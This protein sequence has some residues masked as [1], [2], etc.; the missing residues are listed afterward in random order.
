[1]VSPAGAWLAGGCG[2]E[3]RQGAVETVRSSG[4]SLQ[5]EFVEYA[6]WTNFI[7][8]VWIRLIV[9]SAI[10]VGTTN[11][12]NILIMRDKIKSHCNASTWQP[13]DL[14]ITKDWHGDVSWSDFL[15]HRVLYFSF[16]LPEQF[17]IFWPVVKHG[18]Y[19][20]HDIWPFV[21]NN[22]INWQLISKGY[23]R[24]PSPLCFIL[25]GYEWDPKSTLFRHWILLSFPMYIK[26]YIFS[27]VANYALFFF[28]GVY[29]CLPTEVVNK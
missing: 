16:F 6:L 3:C 27:Y 5:R 8:Y 14:K 13:L 24:P 29:S 28:F 10:Q 15:F 26:A 7:S 4:W 2:F 19:A 1:V 21:S 22:H 17:I 23:P 9:C 11:H 25:W 20:S 12:P 18:N